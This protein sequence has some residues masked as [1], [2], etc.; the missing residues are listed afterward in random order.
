MALFSKNIIKDNKN[1]IVTIGEKNIISISQKLSE[2]NETSLT[3]ENEAWDKVVEQITQIQKVMRELPVEYENLVDQQ[4]IPTLSKAKTEA[5]N[6]IREPYKEKKGFIDKFKSFCDSI[7]NVADIA[8]KVDP[9]VTTI[10]K[11]IGISFP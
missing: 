7:S 2:V 6:I 11:L 8:Q 10:A 5:K 3:C 1:T 4:L 9:F